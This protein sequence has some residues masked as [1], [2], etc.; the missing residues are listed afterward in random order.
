MGPAWPTNTCAHA[1]HANGVTLHRSSSSPTASPSG[2]AENRGAKKSRQIGKGKPARRCPN[3]E[4]VSPPLLPCVSRS[5]R[6]VSCDIG[7][8]TRL[9]RSFHR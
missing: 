3:A 1:V 5:R 4:T 9:C 8:R 6:L 7:D 2:P